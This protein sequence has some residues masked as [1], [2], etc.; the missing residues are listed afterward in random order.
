MKEILCFCINGENI[1]RD[2]ILVEYNDVPIFFICK[3]LSGYYGVLCVDT[4][5]MRYV[6]VRTS[7]IEISR[8]LNGELTMYDF[9]VG[10]A[11]YWE[12]ETST[13]INSD[14]VKL[15]EMNEAVKQ[16]FPESGAYYEI[17]TDD[18]Q[19]YAKRIETEARGDYS[20]IYS[21]KIYSEIFTLGEMEAS[22]YNVIK[23][24]QTPRMGVL[25]LGGYMSIKVSNN[26]E[27]LINYAA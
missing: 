21:K 19:D 13:E 24:V 26:S 8:M 7:S 16:N 10:H 12:V 17:L 20:R 6:V 22:A 5:E 9:F 14:V 2:Q 4:E 18:E 1:Y 27:E 23:T 3:G 15:K 25:T 11:T